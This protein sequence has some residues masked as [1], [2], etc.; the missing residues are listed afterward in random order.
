MTT[1]TSTNGYTVRPLTD[2]RWYGVYDV[3]T[4]RMV[5]IAH[6]RS[7]AMT[8]AASLTHQEA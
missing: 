3:R 7:A 5:H 4:G 8:L 2:M 1:T 6:T